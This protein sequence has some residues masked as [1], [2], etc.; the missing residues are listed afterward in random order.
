M[1]PEQHWASLRIGDICTK[2]GSGATPRGGKEVYL[3][4]GPFTLIRSQNVYNNRFSHDGLVYIN[5]QYAAELNNVEVRTDDVLLNITGD[6]VARACQAP[7]DILPA[8]V[9]Q[10]VAIIRPDPKK[11]SSRFLLY[12]L[13]SPEIQTML[14]SWAGSGGTRNALTKGM[15][16]A[17]IIRAPVNVAEQ[18]AIANIL[19]ILDDK[20]ELNR[21][22]NETLEA[23]ARALFKSWFIDFDPVRAK[24][25]GRDTGLPEHI[26]DLFPRRMVDSE[27]GEIPEGWKVQAL[28]ECFNLTMGQSPPGST[29]N[30]LGD[31]LPFFQGRTDFGFRY[32][33]IRKF[34]SVPK[35]I[36][37]PG[38]TLV[39]VRAPVGDINMA[40]EQYC[41]GRGIAALRHKSKS[42][43]FTYYSA[44]R[45]QK[46]ISEYE[47]TGTVFGA[48]TKKQ[49]EMLHTIEPKPE[50][51]RAFDAFVSP[52][53]ALIRKNT[54]ES[55]SLTSLRNTLLPKLVSGELRIRTHEDHLM[56]NEVE[57]CRF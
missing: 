57:G 21:C 3:S 29:Y 6:S 17:I 30:E 2:I 41:I 35:R 48:I 16:E 15:I 37:N 53:D 39:S 12:A 49:F 46:E 18:Q 50:L 38:D 36:A 8:R 52:M 19:G 24:M 56:S 33:D 4:D 20:I 47:H 34:C 43:S 1:T 10:H 23:M 26:A 9:N 32:P 45:M 31:G 11:L 51:T 14:L 28:N 40:L 22:I 54:Y 13:V 55:Q 42:R 44:W 25:R 5:R 27:L 7:K